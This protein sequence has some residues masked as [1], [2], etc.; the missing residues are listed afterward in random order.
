MQNKGTYIMLENLKK[1]V[2]TEQIEK[3]YNFGSFCV[4][5]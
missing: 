1:V 5:N 2:A 3:V 4:N